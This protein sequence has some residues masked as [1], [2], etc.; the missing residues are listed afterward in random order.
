MNNII[1]L[2]G[3]AD[4][5]TSIFLGGR[6]GISWI[7]IF[8]LIIVILLLVPNIIYAIKEKNQENKCTNKFL[9]LIEQIGRYGCMLLMI[10]NIGLVEFGFSSIGAF[11]VYFLGNTLLMIS[12]WTIWVLYFKKK[13]YWKQ[14]ALALIPTVI[15]LLSGIT[16]QHLLLTFFA[17]VFGIGHLYVTN[18]NRV[19]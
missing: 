5:P 9:N 1:S 17:V 2:I 18:K 19:A 12:Y 13:T 15:F 7:N 16:M 3:G 6:I 4:G 8:G 14:I 11:I 10:F